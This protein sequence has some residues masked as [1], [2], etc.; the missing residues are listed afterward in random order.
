MIIPLPKLDEGVFKPYIILLK[1]N[2]R[3]IMFI[4]VKLKH[5]R[6]LFFKVNWHRTSRRNMKVNFLLEY[7]S[8]YDDAV[9]HLGN[10]G[11]AL[12]LALG[13]SY[14]ISSGFIKRKLAIA[15]V[16]IIVVFWTK[17]VDALLLILLEYFNGFSSSVLSLTREVEVVLCALLAFKH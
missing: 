11:C 8:F 1:L 3:Q 14:L 15:Q 2:L 13:Y 16:C 5:T 12:V 6:L 10:V 7:H 9:H 17:Q 4:G